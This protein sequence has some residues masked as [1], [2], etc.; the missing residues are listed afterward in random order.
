M[1]RAVIYGTGAIYEA[2][3]ASFYKL[4]QK[5]I[6][7]IIGVVDRG[8]DTDFY[9]GCPVLSPEDLANVSA[10][11]V[12]VAANQPA[13][14]S[15]RDDL[16]RVAWQSPRPR[17]ISVFEYPPMQDELRHLEEIQQ[18][19]QMGVIKKILAATDREI[20]DHGWM[21]QMVGKYGIYPFRRED[22]GGGWNVLQ[23]RFL[24]CC[25]GRMSFLDFAC[26]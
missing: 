16:S 25:K 24:G 23:A 22:S 12:I 3:K 14:G 1:D 7:D 18:E 20:S 11:Y 17:I 15:I 5:K 8:I 26:I 9:D 4:S 10:D 6:L 19:I 2:C 21:R 13:A